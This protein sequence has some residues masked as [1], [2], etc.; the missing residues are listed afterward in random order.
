MQNYHCD[1]KNFDSVNPGLSPWPN[2][3]RSCGEMRKS[4]ENFCTSPEKSGISPW[5]SF[6]DKSK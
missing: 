2:F 3:E 1:Y 5:E 4:P 6:N